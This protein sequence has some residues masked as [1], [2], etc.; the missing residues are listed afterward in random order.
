MLINHLRLARTLF[1]VG[2]I[3]CC[4]SMFQ[5]L[6]HLWDTNYFIEGLSDGPNH[7]K[8]HMLREI[9]SDVGILIML[10]ILMFLKDSK[11][12]S[13][14]W[15]LMLLGVSSYVSA[16]WLGYLI[17][18]TGAPHLIASIVHL[19]ITLSLIFSVVLVKKEYIH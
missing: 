7:V 15:T 14:V 13:L 17:L 10:T 3:F 4:I 2:L 9:C 6:S 11:K 8:F 19:V 16:F 1:L 5:T 12:T 18:Q